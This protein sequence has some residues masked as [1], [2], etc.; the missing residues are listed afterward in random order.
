MDLDTILDRVNPVALLAFQKLFDGKKAKDKIA[1]ARKVLAPGDHSVDA[2]LYLTG[3]L[4]ISAE[5]E[6]TPTRNISAKLVMALALSQMRPLERDGFTA[7]LVRSFLPGFDEEEALKPYLSDL[8]AVFE[9][10]EK[11]VSQL[12]K[13]HRAG[14]TKLDVS[15]HALERGESPGEESLKFRAM[16]L[17]GTDKCLKEI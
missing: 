11:V 14:P 8:E 12:P 9:A 15:I 17:E 13:Q 1:E 4:H 6:V 5:Q 2:A 7:L 16:P 3:T 10:I